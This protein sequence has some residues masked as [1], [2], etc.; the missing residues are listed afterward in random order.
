[1]AEIVGKPFN[2]AA[3]IFETR[4]DGHRAIAAINSSGKALVLGTIIDRGLYFLSFLAVPG[5]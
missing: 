1:M 4:L 5:K 3:W 2:D